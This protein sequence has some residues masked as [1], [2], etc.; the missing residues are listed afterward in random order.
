MTSI[1]ELHFEHSHVLRKCL[2]HLDLFLTYSKD[3]YEIYFFLIR[4]TIAFHLTIILEFLYSNLAN[5]RK[6]R[7]QEVVKHKIEERINKKQKRDI[8]LRK[9]SSHQLYLHVNYNF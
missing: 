1:E 2:Y 5:K 3:S 9:L 8:I 4:W 7:F 6:K